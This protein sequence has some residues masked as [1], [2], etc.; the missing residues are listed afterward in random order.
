MK[1]RRAKPGSPFRQERYCSS[2]EYQ[3]GLMANLVAMRCRVL[4]SAEHRELIWFYQW[5]SHRPGG[6]TSAVEEM[7]TLWPE[8]FS[9]PIAERAIAKG[10]M[11]SEA[12]VT[13]VFEEVAA[14]LDGAS[15]SMHDA[16]EEKAVFYARLYVTSELRD[17]FEALA[18]AA[19]SAIDPM[20]IR[21]LFRDAALGVIGGALTSLPD[22]IFKR[23]CLDPAY[24]PD[25][26]RAWFVND[27]AQLLFD[28]KEHVENR[29]AACTV[30]T[31]IGHRIGEALGYSLE[32]HGLVLIEGLE[33]RGKT[34]ATK[35]WC[36]ER[37]GRARYISVPPSSDDI[38]F[39]RAIGQGLGL[40]L[41]DSVKAV[42]LRDNIQETVRD[43]DLMLVFDNAHF[44]FPQTNYREAIPQRVTWV[45]TSLVDEG[46]PVALVTTPQFTL[47]QQMTA[48]KSRWRDQ[49][50]TGRIM[51]FERLPRELS[52]DDLRA[53]ARVYL[54]HADAKSLKLL[55]RYAEGSDKYLQGIEALAKRALYLAKR[56][57]ED[58]PSFEDLKQALESG[59]IPSDSAMVAAV[60]SAKDHLHGPRPGRRKKRRA[61]P[62]AELQPEEI[63][64]PADVAAARRDVLEEFPI[65]ARGVRPEVGRAAAP[66]SMT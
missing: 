26:W 37:P 20:L 29:H 18:E 9:S 25:Q 63:L 33:R 65:P 61:T 3:R 58:R 4:D 1:T 59:I 31:D 53:V 13:T 22:L 47:T 48:E 24:R 38:G 32:T 66:V 11:L 34:H 39:F 62:V 49:Q 45:L 46:V 2:P 57:G 64:T 51:H 30:K 56:R 41:A 12:D 50:L 14:R 36:D 10:K 40:S 28:Y 15:T 7:V 55:I 43:R 8:R 35:A 54:P 6:I 42:Q 19:Q 52:E 17:H 23:I 16:G 27:L 60:E 21:Q 5:L 44:L